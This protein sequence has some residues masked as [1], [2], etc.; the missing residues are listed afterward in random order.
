MYFART[1]V[2]VPTARADRR[3][4]RDPKIHFAIEEQIFRQ[5]APRVIG[6][7]FIVGSARRRR[8]RGY[9]AYPIRPL[10]GKVG[11]HSRAVKGRRV[12]RS[13]RVLPLE[14]VSIDRVGL[15]ISRENG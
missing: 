15:L 9:V 2:E 5:Q 7:T 8:G 6:V 3:L 12:G 13:P 14:S 1:V 10:Q 4:R 11:D